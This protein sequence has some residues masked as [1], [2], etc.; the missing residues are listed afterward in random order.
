[1]G[2]A[3]RQPDDFNP[4]PLYATAEP[5]P[6]ARPVV[7]PFA[8]SPSTKRDPIFL[9]DEPRLVTLWDIV[10]LM[11]FVALLDTTAKY[12]LANYKEIALHRLTPM[13]DLQSLIVPG[14][15]TRAG[16]SLIFVGIIIAFRRQTLRAI[17]LSFRQFVTNLLIGIGAG[18]GIL[19]FGHLIII[20]MTV[21]WPEILKEMSKNA[22]ELMKLIP[23]MTTAQS[24]AFMLMVGTYEE[25]LF[26]GFLLPRLRRLTDSWIWATLISTTIFTALHAMDQVGAALVAI[27]GLSLI[28]SALTIWRRSIVPGIIAHFL[29]NLVQL[30]AMNYMRNHRQ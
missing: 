12:V 3:P 4:H 30:L 24:A 21:I 7:H 26:R 15:S 6:L 22:D 29:F 1:M 13:E 28:F 9:E 2:D 14:I 16:L 20:T 23:N 8:I 17:G 18:V 11:T 19:L 10:V 25:V 5:V 27:T